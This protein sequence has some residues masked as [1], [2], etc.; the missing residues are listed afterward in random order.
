MILMALDHT[1]DFFTE[2]DF[3]PTD[4]AETTPA[5]FVTRWVTHLCAPTFVF[6]AGVSAHLAGRRRTPRELSWFLFSRGAFLVV[7]ELTVV[8]LAW[9]FD[10]YVAGGLGVQVIW[11]IGASMILL[12]GMVFLPRPAILA[13]AILVIVLHNAFDGVGGDSAIAAVLHEG[14]AI[15][16]GP[17]RV[18]IAY[19]LIPWPF[20]MALGYALAP[21]FVDAEQKRSVLLAG[22]GLLVVFVGLRLANV[23]GD[24]SPWSTQPTLTQTIMSFF[25][26]TKY[27]PSLLYLCATLGIAWI[28]VATCERVPA[29]IAV[30]GRAPLFFY[31]LHLYLIHLL[32]LVV[33]VAQGYDASAMAAGFFRYPDGFGFPL[34]V[35]YGIT[36]LVVA[37]LY[38]P[39]RWFADLKAR[40]RTWWLS[41][42]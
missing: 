34:Y 28:G 7:L 6:L 22:I 3:D 18:Y 19:P 2:A 10:A 39:T 12:C 14:G 1:R 21:M 26:V 17:L 35:V 20:V 24:A 23:Y 5:Y 11:A 27:P 9:R 8:Q 32:A 29:F 15:E 30:F 13:I 31:V 36:A 25:D 16:L 4:V 33:G 42:L 38:L 41:Y 37:A 40:H